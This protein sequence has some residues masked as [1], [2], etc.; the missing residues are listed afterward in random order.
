M[1]TPTVSNFYVDN[2][3]FN[4]IFLEPNDADDLVNPT[5]TP[6][7]PPS[8]EVPS[9]THVVQ[10]VSNI[11][12]SPGGKENSTSNV[13]KTKAK[14]KSRVQICK[15]TTAPLGPKNLNTTASRSFDASASLSRSS[16]G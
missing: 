11:V 4:P 5:E 12:V 14:G 16:K 3:R 1:S 10:N 2:S 9:E 15:S 6:Q 8:G 7:V 13:G